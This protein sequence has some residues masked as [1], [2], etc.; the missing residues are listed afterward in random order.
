MRKVLLILCVIVLSGCAHY[1]KTTTHFEGETSGLNPYGKGDVKVVR[2]SHW[3]WG[4][5]SIKKLIEQG[6][7]K[8]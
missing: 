8:N 2:E 7:E 6:N 4:I 3:A 5:K 1:S